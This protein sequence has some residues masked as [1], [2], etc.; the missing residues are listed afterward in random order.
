MNAALALVMALC[1]A[2]LWLAPLGSSFWLDETVTA[3]VVRHGGGDPSLAIA[4]QVP[5]S[6]YYWLPRISQWLFGKSEIAFRLPSVLAMGAALFLIFRL[7]TRLV[8]SRAGWFAAFACLA[9][10]GFNYQASDARPYALGTCLWAAALLVLVRWLDS[11]EWKY[12]LSFII[13][14]ALVWRTQLVFWPF[15]LIAVFYWLI[16]LLRRETGVRWGRAGGVFGLA[17]LSL[18]PVLIDALAVLRHAEAHVIAGPP[19]F[20]TLEHALRWNVVL[21]LAGGAF[22]LSRIFRWKRGEAPGASSIALAL[23]WWLFPALSLFVYSW[24]TGNSV[25]IPRYISPM[26]PGVALTGAA[27]AAYF[28]PANIWNRLALALGAGVLLFMGQW[29]RLWPAHEGSDWRGAAR[30]VNTRVLDSS[31]PII[32]PSPFI[33]ARAPEW[34]PDYRLPGFLYAHLDYYPVKGR[35]LLLPFDASP[36]AERYAAALSKG[37][38]PVSR[39][40]LLYGW[41]V[42]YWQNWLA[43]RPELRQWKVVRRDFGDVSV[44]EFDSPEA[45]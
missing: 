39:R 29:G 6:I 37:A 1:V 41:N 15:Y 20:H 21:I 40:F 12:G 27:L 44:V 25:F 4:P 5:M 3:F 14:A 35:T 32:C 23:G 36:E 19:S 13:C 22:A 2:R 26:L 28:V 7:A 43:S 33:E 10:S 8:H 18:A 24:I 30:E 31:T 17:A 45:Y 11:A 34:T 16:R 42:S 38:L 9:L